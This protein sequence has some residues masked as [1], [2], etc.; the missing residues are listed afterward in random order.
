V[1]L[2]RE[3]SDA[4]F[5]RI[6]QTIEEEQRKMTINRDLIQKVLKAAFPDPLV[7]IGEAVIDVAVAAMQM[8]WRTEYQ[9]AFGVTRPDS[10][11][12]VLLDAGAALIATISPTTDAIYYV[13]HAT[14]LRH[15]PFTD[16]FVAHLPHV[17]IRLPEAGEPAID[18]GAGGGI[19]YAG[20]HMIFNVAMMND[21]LEDQSLLTGEHLEVERVDL[22]TPARIAG[23][24]FA[25]V[26]VYL[27]YRN[28]ADAL[29][30]GYVL[31]GGMATGQARTLYYA[32]GMTPIVRRSFYQPTPS[33]S[34]K[35]YYRGDFRLAPPNQLSTEASPEAVLKIEAFRANP[36]KDPTVLPYH[37]TTV[38]FERV[39]TPALVFPALL[40][41]QAACRV[42]LIEH[43]MGRELPDVGPLTGLLAELG[44][45]LPW[46]V[47]PQE[48]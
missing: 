45:Q 23:A 25:A 26:A 41:L 21:Y 35:N 9:D 13:G 31:E 7:E 5:A 20:D 44:R 14:H 34:A 12:N 40:T 43:T 28:A 6:S 36:I 4:L 16:Q 37:T 27:L 3:E 38:R 19:V 22:I 24:R 18:T 11:V 10:P 39:S 8:G 30:V 47:L 1:S 2:S 33:S 42:A 32:P 48:T 29:P 15:V 17:R 46:D